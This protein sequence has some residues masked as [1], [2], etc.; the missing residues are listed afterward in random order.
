MILLRKFQLAEIPANV[1]S[2]VPLT[3]FH[4][5]NFGREAVGIWLNFEGKDGGRECH[6]AIASLVSNKIVIGTYS[7]NFG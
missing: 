7:H 1:N 6:T 4:G 3:V 5:E 2:V